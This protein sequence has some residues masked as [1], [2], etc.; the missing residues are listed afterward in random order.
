MAW[1]YDLLQ[2]HVAQLVV[3]NPVKNALFRDGNKSDRIDARKLAELLRGNHLKPVYHGE[4][5]VRMQRELARSY[6]PIVRDLTCH[7]SAESDVSQLAPAPAEAIGGLPC[8]LTT[9]FSQSRRT[10]KRWSV[11]TA[12][13]RSAPPSLP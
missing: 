13:I 1:L 2:P 5:D 6:P 3:C 10:G 4:T 9:R 8:C 11:R 7:E 12:A